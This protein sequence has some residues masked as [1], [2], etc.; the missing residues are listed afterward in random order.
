MK[1]GTLKMMVV[2]ATFYYKKSERSGNS[3]YL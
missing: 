1:G 2:M 3:G